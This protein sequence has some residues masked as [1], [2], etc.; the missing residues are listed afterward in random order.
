M[1]CL[2]YD[3]NFR[4][5]TILLHHVFFTTYFHIIYPIM[6]GALSLRGPISKPDGYSLTFT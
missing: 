5:S 4:T 2:T 3:E 1:I 6:Q